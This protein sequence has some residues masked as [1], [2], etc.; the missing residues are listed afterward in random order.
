MS[1][2]VHLNKNRTLVFSSRFSIVDCVSSGSD[3]LPN[4][5]KRLQGMRCVTMTTI[6]II[7][8][9]D[10]LED[11]SYSDIYYYCRFSTL[12]EMRLERFNNKPR[13]ER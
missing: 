7:L 12:N 9:N 1:L 6:R 3:V 4:C 5:G 10:T 8:T 2:S 11:S 13:G